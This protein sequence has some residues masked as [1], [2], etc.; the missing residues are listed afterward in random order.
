MGEP[1]VL[2]TGAS[3]F[4]GRHLARALARDGVEVAGIGPASWAEPERRAWGISMW[5]PGEVSTAALRELPRAPSVVFHCAG[6]GSVGRAEAHPEEDHRRSV[7][8]LAI[9]LDHL[10]RRAPG[11]RVVFPS[12]AAVYGS[13]E[14]PVREDAPPCPSSVYARH[15]LAA[16]RLLADHGE[17]AGSASAIVRLTSVYG[18]GLRKQLLWDACS[19]LSRG[20]GRFQGTGRELR[21]WLH[22]DD[23][24][25]LLRLAGDRAEPGANVVNGGSGI[26][27]SVADVL[28]VVASALRWSGTLEFS[29]ERRAGDPARLLVD[30]GQARAWGWNADRT[31]RDGVVAYCDW[32]RREAAR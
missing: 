7:E 3:G 1:L 13:T 24:V 27:V 31:W 4:I 16:E 19:K 20:D 14:H 18:A 29:G 21:D 30:V 11:A 15:K 22:V 25:R 32:F 23:V 2:V 17:R 28:S 8:S 12:S 9:L 26:P 10:R 6:A 5:V